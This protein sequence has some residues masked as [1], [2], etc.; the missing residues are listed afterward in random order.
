MMTVGQL[1]WL[2]RRART[3]AGFFGVGVWLAMGN[4]AQDAFLTPMV[5]RTSL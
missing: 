2:C 3:G 1:V 4:G 5:K